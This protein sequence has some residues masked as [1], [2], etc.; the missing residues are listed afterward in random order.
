MTLTPF[1]R[2]IVLLLTT[3]CN[4]D[5]VYCYSGQKGNVQSMGEPALEPELIEWI[6]SFIR[7]KNLPATIG[8]QTNGTIPDASLIRMFKRYDI[9]AGVSPDG[10]PDFH[11]KLRRQSGPTIKGLKLLS[12]HD[13]PFR[14]TCA[15]TGQNV[16]VMD[17]LALFLGSFPTASGL[18]LDLLVCK[19]YALKN[20]CASP[21]SPEE[22]K[23]G[24][25]KLVQTLG[26]INANRSHL[27]K[28]R[29]LESLKQA[30]QKGNHLHFCHASK[31]EAAAIHP[32]GTIYP[33]AQTVGDP[34][35]A[36]GTVDAPNKESFN[37]LGKYSLRSEQ[38]N[39]CPVSGFCPGD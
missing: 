36:C 15:V 5:C 39:D 26:W 6:A 17:Q 14:V 22:L 37:V 10:P 25:K 27:I 7:K 24:F 2:Y 32:D 21:P 11:E 35:F 30:V 8:I 33:C 38:C 29:E 31:G 12:D 18:A 34:C 19:G 16:S 4:L 23:N 28:L 1:H 9:Q 20:D 13:L 3:A